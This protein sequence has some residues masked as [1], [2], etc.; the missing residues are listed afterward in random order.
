MSR[1]AARMP[2]DALWPQPAKP[3]QPAANQT[4]SAI[5]R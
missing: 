3:W 2:I 1:L 5:G 4:E